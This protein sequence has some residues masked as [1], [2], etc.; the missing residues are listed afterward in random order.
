M[1]KK[2]KRE[3]EK[4]PRNRYSDN[5][6]DF[7][8]LASL[9]PSFGSYVFY[10]RDGKPK[11]DWK[12]FNATRELT[13]VL[14][15]HH[16]SVTW[17]IPDGQLCPTVPNRSNYIHWIEDLLSSNIIP[18]TRQDNSLVKGLDIGTGANCIYPLLGAS[19]LGWSFV[20]TDVTDVALEWAD[21][22]VKNNPHISELIEIRKVDFE[23]ELTHQHTNSI[24]SS[25]DI[26]GNTE[27]PKQ[28]SFGNSNKSYNGPPILLDVVKEG[29]KFDF[30]M[31][32]PP[33]FETMEESG[34]N[35]NTSCGGTPAEMV[36]PGGE[37]AFVSRMIQDSIQLKQSF[38]WYTSMV[39]K[40]SSLKSLTSKLREAG[41]TVVKT[42]EFVQGQTCRWGIAWSFVPPI[43]KI[44]SSH[45]ASKNVLTFMLEGIQRKFSAF[46]VLN[47]IESFF[48]ASGA[49]SNKN[50]ALFFIDIHATMSD[51][52]EILKNNSGNL[53]EIEWGEGL[54]VLHFRVTVFEQIPGTLLVRG[55]LKPGET[56][57]PGLLSSIFLQVE[58]ALRK[59]FC[60]KKVN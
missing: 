44:I 45:V 11:I 58:D 56:S 48:Q 57:V 21:W 26:T 55:S 15:L 33:F 43:K 1:G 3:E 7:S 30:C 12:D 54:N 49:S 39:G 51:C 28:A 17:W 36:C 25:T 38:R 22:N 59:E 20:G 5:P 42:T 60:P 50:A 9:Y 40:K 52:K 24:E 47:S 32:N 10:S 18:N 35:P 13:R 37:Q 16:H 6:P 27:H 19:L 2:R 46:H 4:H 8:E 31:C 53:K 29:E 34:L 14:L 23:Q 41:V